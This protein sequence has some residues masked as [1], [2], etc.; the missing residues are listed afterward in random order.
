MDSLFRFKY[1]SVSNYKSALKVGTDAVT[2]GACIELP[3][4]CRTVLDIGTGTGVIA[5]MIAQKINFVLRDTSDLR[6]QSISAIDIDKASCEEAEENFKN[7]PWAKFLSV[8]NISLQ[9]YKP[10]E[11]F[12]LIF[13]NPPYFEN[14]LKNPDN[15]TSTARHTDSL[16]FRDICVFSKEYLK[17]CLWVILPY[18]QLINSQRLAASFGLFLFK[19]ITIYSSERK[20]AKRAILAFSKQQKS[21][22]KE[23]LILNRSGVRSEEYMELTKDYLL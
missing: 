19:Q 14:S 2:L 7:S 21:I 3:E 23:D 11:Q 8:E 18:D 22:L 17:G 4:D 6:P 20:S 1:F 16:C 9:D 10:K 5:L 12:D 15:R 13:S